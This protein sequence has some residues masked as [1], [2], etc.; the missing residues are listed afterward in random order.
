M[1]VQR[2]MTRLVKGLENMSCE[3]QLKK[4]RLF[5]LEERRLRGEET[6]LLFSNT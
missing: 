4:L 6:L 1:K 3:E 5:S 2:R